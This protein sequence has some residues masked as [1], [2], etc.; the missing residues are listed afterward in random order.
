MPRPFK[1]S[2]TSEPS[3][4]KKLHN[5]LQAWLLEFGINGA[6]GHDILLATNEAFLN[7]IEDSQEHV[8][9]LIAI[10]AQ[11]AERDVVIHLHRP[12]QQRRPQVDAS[13]GRH[14][15]SL[16]TALMNNVRIDRHQNGTSITLRKTL[17]RVPPD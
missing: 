2:L 16:L 14:S 8:T 6:I 9:R 12:A 15:Q 4:A 13:P 1:L 3:E 7:A 11:V 17:D 5:E 10:S